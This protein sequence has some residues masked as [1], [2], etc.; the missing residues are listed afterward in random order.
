M[1][2]HVFILKIVYK[3]IIDYQYFIYVFDEIYFLEIISLIIYF[4]IGF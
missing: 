2:F 4:R 1:F 3:N